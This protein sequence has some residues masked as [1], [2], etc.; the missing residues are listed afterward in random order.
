MFGSVY[1]STYKGVVINDIIRF[2][3][4]DGEDFEF[5]GDAEE[6]IDGYSS[7]YEY[8]ENTITWLRN[9]NNYDETIGNIK[10]AIKLIVLPKDYKNTD[11]FINY[12][13][14]HDP[15]R[16]FFH[17][18]EEFYDKKLENS[19][20]K[21]NA[22]SQSAK[23]HQ[24]VYIGNYCTI[25]DNVEIGE[26][27]K[28]YNNVTIADNVKIGTGCIIK[29][30]AVIGEEGL[31]YMKEKDGTYRRVPHL[32][33][34]VIGNN[35]DV[36]ANT[37]IERGAMEDTVIENGV[38]IDDLCQI[39]HNVHIGENTMIV[40]NTNVYGSSKIGKNCWIASSIIRNQVKIGDNVIVGMGSIVTKDVR[41]NATVFGSPAKE[42]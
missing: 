31:G 6:S 33:S 37:T 18:I 13:K 27:S 2:L 21:E 8:K 11:E 26:G 9:S 17:I 25:G 36:G 12:I 35:V 20:G 19:I 15:H 7:I 10:G 34:V 39:S 22:I 30:G 23:I 16:V 5:I 14:T 28:I 41:S 3:Q 40:V 32:G 4:K 29:S 38:K 1:M 42:R 24:N